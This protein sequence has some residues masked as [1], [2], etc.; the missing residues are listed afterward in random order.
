MIQASPT[1]I[2]LIACAGF[3]L[4]L[5]LMHIMY[6]IKRPSVRIHAILSAWFLTAAF[7]STSRLMQ[8]FSMDLSGGVLFGKTSAVSHYI[9]L[10]LGMNFVYEYTQKKANRFEK[11]FWHTI[12][13]VSVLFI[14]TSEIYITNQGVL[15]QT[16]FGEKFYG[17]I[18]GKY[19][20]VFGFILPISFMFFFL[21]LWLAKNIPEKSLYVIIGFGFC[22]FFSFIDII[23][24]Q[25][26]LNFIRF[27]DYAYLPLGLGYTVAMIKHHSDMY[28]QMEILV[29]KRTEELLEANKKL[30]LE[31]KTRT[32][33]EEEALINKDRFESIY[34]GVNEAI[35]IHNERG[36]IVDVN[37][38][39]LEMFKCSKEQALK[40]KIEEISEN[41]TP[42]TVHE[43]HEFLKRAMDG[44]E[45]VFDWRAKDFESNLFWAENHM[46]GVNIGKE[47]YVI[48]TTRDI[49]KRKEIDLELE[50]YRFMLEEKVQQRTKELDDAVHEQIFLNDEL[51]ALNK[52]LENQKNELM[53]AMENL[54][55]AQSKIIESEKMAA[56]GVLIS[57]IAHEINNPLNYI[58]SSVSNFEGMIDETI[59]AIQ[60]D[61]LEKIK[62]ITF[63]AKGNKVSESAIQINYE[64][65]FHDL[66]K[67]IS[68]ISIGTNKIVHI[69]KGLRL[70]SR[71]DRDSKVE[72]DIHEQLDAVLVM[73]NYQLKDRI[74]VIKQYG[75]IPKI[76]CYA[77]KLGQV[78]L[79]LI[80]N[81]IHAIEGEGKIIIQT[82]PS[83]D[84]SKIH[85][86]FS[87][88]GIG[89]Q[90]EN[91]TKIFVPF[92]TTKE[93]GKGIG[94]GLSIV[95]SI[96][97]EH[98]G[99][100]NVTS[101][102][103]EG[104][105]FTIT[106]PVEH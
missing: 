75:E 70:F 73:M 63:T 15:R 52:E 101:L 14:I 91:L 61:T 100:I 78:F 31:I 94:L 22:A 25:F 47:K 19:F 24:I 37:D 88:N 66:R 84:R 92:Y 53:I 56:L 86:A 105:K 44:E 99:T 79:N 1:V 40:C 41:V 20:M 85:I 9:L 43:S 32:E 97:E 36:E 103:N 23:I 38:K 13:S 28:N 7:F 46:R 62:S 50:N 68:Y 2:G 34:N 10:W 87:D 11:I 26:E 82:F 104:T 59:T 95:F 64:Q 49:T 81:A 5:F 96:I 83:E 29:D 39:M 98:N 8:F 4:F 27:Y 71:S 60:N 45:L 76:K 106:L 16:I 12:L 51:L 42:Y 74:E 57:G 48:V 72:A 54:K 17:A 89:I 102:I 93:V 67:L 80:S 33:A 65:Y 35:F 18:G 55:L 3:E 90:E 6:W 58:S 21:K 69:V 30:K 77:S